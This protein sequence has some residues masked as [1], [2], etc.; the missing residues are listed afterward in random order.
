MYIS[1]TKQYYKESVVALSVPYL[2]AAAVQL[3]YKQ[4]LAIMHVASFAII[5][6]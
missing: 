2:H 1:D 3:L 5:Y 4:R 6:W